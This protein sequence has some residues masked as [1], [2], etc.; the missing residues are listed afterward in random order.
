[1]KIMLSFFQ[2][3]YSRCGMLDS[4]VARHTLVCVRV[5]I[6]RLIL[7]ATTL[8]QC[9]LI[10]QYY[11]STNSKIVPRSLFLVPSSVVFSA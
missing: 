9:I 7:L 8:L 1:M 2:S 11:P 6:Q 3:I 10:T 4:W 5:L